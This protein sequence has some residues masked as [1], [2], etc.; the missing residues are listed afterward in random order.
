MLC[1]GLLS[2]LNEIKKNIFV[3]DKDFKVAALSQMILVPLITYICITFFFDIDL[4]FK[5]FLMLIALAPGAI[6]STAYVNLSGGNTVLSLKLSFYLTILS[7]FTLPILFK[8]YNDSIIDGVKIDIIK[9]ILKISILVILPIFIGAKIKQKFSN[10]NNRL[11][12]LIAVIILLFGSVITFQIFDKNLTME[13]FNK[14]PYMLILII[15]FILSAALLGVIFKLK[16]ENRITLII[17]TFMQNQ[18]VVLTIGSITMPGY[19]LVVSSL[20][21]MTIQFVFGYI[22]IFMN[23]KK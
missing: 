7:A 10:L 12:K 11:I 22:L 9:A 21:W 13:Y 18:A 1:V 14:I 15:F 2:S 4:E 5:I 20:L 17:E 16:K 19:T 23:Y 3:F 6:V 8:I